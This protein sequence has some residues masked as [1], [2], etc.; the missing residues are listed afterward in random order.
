MS[1]GLAARKMIPEDK[2]H[3]LSIEVLHPHHY[4]M[5]IE[6]YKRKTSGPNN[7]QFGNNQF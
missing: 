3:I 5:R 2:Y 4:E 7:Y 1:E 6:S